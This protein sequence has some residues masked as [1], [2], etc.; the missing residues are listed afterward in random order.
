M[1]QKQGVNSGGLTGAPRV[2]VVEDHADT[3]VLLG[4]LLAKIAID[5]IPT[6][7]CA[8]A[9]SAVQR[10]GG[11]DLVIA[12]HNLPDGNGADL[13]AGFKEQ[14]DCRTVVVSGH[15][16]PEGALPTGVDEWVPKP[17]DLAALTRVVQGLMRK[18]AQGLKSA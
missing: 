16:A 7:D 8:T 17:V 9:R 4:K 5:A 12:D 3:L 18:Q 13:V 10:F 14:F 6:Q 11:F 2:L 1:S 15:P